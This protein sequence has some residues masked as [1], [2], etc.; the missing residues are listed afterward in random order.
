MDAEW[1][2]P[3][4]PDSHHHYWNRRLSIRC[5]RCKLVDGVPESHS[6]SAP[7]AVLRGFEAHLVTLEQIA[8]IRSIVSVTAPL[9]VPL[10]LNLHQVDVTG[11][12]I[13]ATGRRPRPPHRLSTD[14]PHTQPQQQRI[15]SAIEHLINNFLQTGQVLCHINSPHCECIPVILTSSSGFR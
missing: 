1:C 14:Y 9:A 4:A 12:M 7:E 6:S 8:P 15:G 13:E 2:V 5:W 3:A 10:S 11:R